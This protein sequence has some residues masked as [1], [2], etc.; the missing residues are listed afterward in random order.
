MPRRV[1]LAWRTVGRTFGTWLAPGLTLLSFTVLRTSV[2]LGMTLDAILISRVRQTRVMRPIVIV[3][4]PRTG[5]TFLHRFMHD[6]GLGAGLQLWKMLFPSVVLQRI[7]KPAL[8]L[9][10]KVS[11]ARHH[12]TVAHETSLTSVETD[13]AAVLFRYFDGYFLYGFLLAWADQEYRDWFDPER[14]DT[15]ARD[16]AWM[17][18]IWRRNEAATGAPRTIAKVFSLGLRL[19]LF[20]QKFPDAKILY[21]ARDPVEAIPSAMSLV[22]GVL[23]KRFGFWKLPAETR[24]KYLDRLYLALVQLLRG[25]YEDYSSG[26]I[27]RSRVMIVPFPR[28]MRDFEKLMGEIVAFVDIQPDDRL[29]A[30]ITRVAVEQRKFKSAHSYDGARFGLDSEKVRADCAFF[31]DAFLAEPHREQAATAGG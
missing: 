14:R 1:L 13:D 27:D 12:S 29:K 2:A 18:Q 5:T 19:P 20:L 22:T 9:L 16:F 26:K 6:Q 3:G 31:Y 10:E 21:T 8:P 15:S 30:E 24:Q 4:N 7:L 28:L 23:D 17:E 25:F 11:P